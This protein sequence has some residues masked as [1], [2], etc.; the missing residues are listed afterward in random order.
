MYGTGLNTV[1]T[2][3]KIMVGYN[4]N[5]IQ[6]VTY[7]NDQCNIVLDQENAHHNIKRLLLALTHLLIQFRVMGAVVALLLIAQYLQILV[8]PGRIH[9]G[10]SRY[11]N[12]W[13]K[14]EMS[15]VERSILYG[16]KR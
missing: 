14:T 6:S 16:Y 5:R 1:G 13:S 7:M 4:S 8:I 9:F 15:T 11:F 3:G 12:Y 2:Y 10:L